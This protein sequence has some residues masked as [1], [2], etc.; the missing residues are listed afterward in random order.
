MI[1][2]YP[3]ERGVILPTMDYMGK[4]CAKEVLFQAVSI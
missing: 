3:W 1:L 2:E 4:L